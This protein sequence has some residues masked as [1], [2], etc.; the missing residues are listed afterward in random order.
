MFQGVTAVKRFKIKK[1]EQLIETNT[2]LLTFNMITLPK[3]VRIF[4]RI[5]PVEI[6]VPILEFF[7]T[8][9]SNESDDG[10]KLSLKSVSAKSSRFSEEISLSKPILATQTQFIL[11][12]S[13]LILCAQNFIIKY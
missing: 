9:F 4:Y 8:N 2:F 13:I 6:Y 7:W 5:T 11:Q 1:G 12:K 3:S 10:E